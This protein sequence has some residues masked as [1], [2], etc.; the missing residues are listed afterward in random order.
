MHSAYETVG[1]KDT[2]YLVKAIENF[3]SYS[4]TQEENGILVLGK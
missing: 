4:I 2:Y 1:I 3:Y